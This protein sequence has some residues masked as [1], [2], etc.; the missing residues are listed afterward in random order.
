MKVRPITKTIHSIFDGSCADV[1][2][3]PENEISKDRCVVGAIENPT[4]KMFWNFSRDCSQLM[5]RMS[6][7]HETS[8][9]M[10][11][12]TDSTH[13]VFFENIIRINRERDI[14]R[15]FFWEFVYFQFPE[16]RGSDS[17]MVNKNWVITISEEDADDS[18]KPIFYSGHPST[19]FIEFAVGICNGTKDFDFSINFLPIVEDEKMLG[20]IDNNLIRQILYL[21]EGLR[22]PDWMK[23]PKFNDHKSFMSWIKTKTVIEATELQDKLKR[24][25]EQMYL[26]DSWFWL[27]VKDFIP[28]ARKYPSIAVRKDWYLVSMPVSVE[29]QEID[30]I[31]GLDDLD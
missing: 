29:D 23:L 15:R 27:A 28:E 11:L 8:H 30:E 18:G 13:S 10:G 5:K 24:I 25:S 9:Q 19:R 1:Y 22:N 14:F 20:K 4:A 26:L 21:K 3:E 31:L 17:V 6:K 16:I 7:E 12:C 2:Y